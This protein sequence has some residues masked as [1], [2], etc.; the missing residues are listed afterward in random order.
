MVKNLQRTKHL[1]KV[2]LPML[3]NEILRLAVIST[4]L[5]YPMRKGEIEA[6]TIDMATTPWRLKLS[7]DDRKS[8]QSINNSLSR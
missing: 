2:L 4:L 6:C 8:G 1:Q 7:M 5:K 3:Q